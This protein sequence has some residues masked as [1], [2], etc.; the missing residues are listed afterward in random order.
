LKK[1]DLS[2]REMRISPISVSG[3]RCLMS[4]SCFHN[5]VIIPLTGGAKLT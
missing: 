3:V 4:K 2:A 1:K 5:D